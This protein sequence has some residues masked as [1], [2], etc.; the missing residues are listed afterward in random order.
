MIEIMTIKKGTI[1]D[2]KFIKGLVLDHGGRHP[3]MPEKLNKS[4]VLACNINLEYEK[5]EIHSGFFFSNP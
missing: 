3:K 5:T 2:S 4:F 1:F